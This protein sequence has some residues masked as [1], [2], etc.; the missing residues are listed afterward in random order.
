MAPEAIDQAA[1]NLEALA[2]ILPRPRA[3]LIWEGHQFVDISS[4]SLNLPN[5]ECCEKK[6]K[7]WATVGEG[8][9]E[10]DRSKPAYDEEATAEAI[11]ATHL[12]AADVVE[13]ANV[14]FVQEIVPP[15]GYVQP[16]LVN[17]DRATVDLRPAYVEEPPV[18]EANPNF[19]EAPEGAAESVN[20]EYSFQA[21]QEAY[22]Y[23]P[24]FDDS[25]LY[26]D[27]VGEDFVEVLE[28]EDDGQA[29]DL[30]GMH[31]Q[32]K[33]FLKDDSEQFANAEE[34]LDQERYKSMYD[35][36]RNTFGFEDFR[37]RQKATVVA[38]LLDF[39]CF[40]LMPT[41]AGKSLCYQ[42]PA[43]MSKGLTVVVSPLRSL[44]E[45]QK[46][47]MKQLRVPC[48]ALTSDL[49]QSDVDIIF[50]QLTMKDVPLKL[51]YVTPEKI[52][53]S[54]KLRS[55]FRCL[56]RRGQLARFVIDEAHCV[57]QWGHDFRPDYVS[58]SASLRR[59]YSDPPVPI[60][61]LT[62]TATPKIVADTKDHLNIRSS[63]LFISSFVRDNLKYHLV[64]KSPKCFATVME[65]MKSEYPR[66]SGIVYCLSRKECE[67]V[68]GSLAKQGI[69]AAVYHAG[70]SDK[71]RSEV[72]MK[73]INDKVQV[74]C[75]T[76]AFGMGIDKPNVRFVI[77]YSLPKS[78]EGYY[79]ETGR[80]GRDGKN[81]TCILLYSYQDSIRLRRMIEGE[82]STAGARNMHLKS[83]FEVVAY[84]ENVYTCR[85]KILVEHFGEVYDS[86]NC[87]R[88]STTCTVCEAWRGY[89]M[90]GRE[91]P[92]ILVDVSDEGIRLLK[93]VNSMTKVTLKYIAGIYRGSPNDKKIRDQAASLGHNELE[94][95]RRGEALTE[96]E[97]LRF[98]RKL[99]LLGFLEEKLFNGAYD[100]VLAYA[101]VT[102][103]GRAATCGR[104]PF[105]LLLP[106]GATR[107]NVIVSASGVDFRLLPRVNEVDTIKQS[108]G[109]KHPDVNR[110]CKEELTK[111][112]ADFVSAGTLLANAVPA[113][114][115][116][117]IASL[118]PRTKSEMLELP[119]ITKAIYHRIGEGV[120]GV[121]RR[122]WN[123]LDKREE[124]EIQRDLSKLKTGELVM[125]GFSSIPSSSA[126]QLSF[127]TRAASQGSS[128]GRGRF[129]G[130][131]GKS[132]RKT[133]QRKAI[134]G[135]ASK[136]RSTRGRRGG[137]P[138][139]LNPNMFPS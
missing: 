120:F 53:A 86:E 85:R 7:R 35:V 9:F 121:L 73:W 32:F 112:F 10:R 123:E 70:L 81:G 21:L 130:G 44:I 12:A 89:K 13:D 50:S 100:Q 41:G 51:L 115:I 3:R 20:D 93:A 22:G 38:A 119:G 111:L 96:E 79:Q 87:L 14:E 125:G 127:G 104:V 106:I 48:E 31:G 25:F 36:L 61:A 62:A 40:V 71:Q 72:Q 47:K 77:H 82:N 28:E 109:E 135:G 42:L 56:H 19:Y 95:Y 134:E 52:V 43:I 114:T 75:A 69:P 8:D 37:H 91:P 132:I 122:F 1:E 105:K 18:Q 78:I 126:D 139:G 83:I 88:S 16:Q 129:R 17:V 107:P 46:Y 138:A 124:A 80:A 33:S 102:M 65:K 66:Q 55:M 136:G 63:K 29:I 101:N 64:P 39:D 54:E 26:D 137:G 118:M 94:I 45:D 5:L 113:A 60:M 116:E 128:R 74:I 49:S 59:E 57:S 34:F 99:V 133:T 92:Y 68:Q 11:F 131:R 110:R 67:T 98:V 90:T 15:V 4:L 2:V 6:H 103:M 97:S 108:V 84:C 24:A 76:I 30:H 58:A 23:D 27:G 117:K